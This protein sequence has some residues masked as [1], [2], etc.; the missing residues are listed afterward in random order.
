MAFR[1][2]NYD[3]YNLHANSEAIQKL[4]LHGFKVS[5]TESKKNYSLNIKAI[6]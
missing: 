4:R 2:Q 5:T 6:Y 3:K 1:I